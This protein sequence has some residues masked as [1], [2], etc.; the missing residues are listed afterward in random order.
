MPQFLSDEWFD[1]VTKLNQDA[2]P[3][4]L[5][6]NLKH[7]I[8]TIN[9]QDGT[10]FHFKEGKIW[11]GN[12]DNPK[13]TLL[14]TKNILQSLI[15]NKDESLAIEAFIAGDIRVE[16]DMSALLALQSVK[17]TPEQKQLYKDILAMTQFD[18]N[19]NDK[20]A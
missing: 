4:N 11:Q 9:L 15:Q 2:N 19:P 8:L 18:D 12:H 16:G 20:P 3:L 10:H 1:T 17:P 5:P 7:L 13:A 6:P 14:M